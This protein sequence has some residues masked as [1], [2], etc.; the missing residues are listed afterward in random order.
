MVCSVCPRV[1]FPCVYLCVCARFVLCVCVRV[2]DCVCVCPPPHQRSNN[3]VY[4]VESGYTGPLVVQQFSAGLVYFTIDETTPTTTPGS[5]V[6]GYYLR[7]RTC[8]CVCGCVWE[9]VCG[10]VWEVVRVRV[11][12]CVRMCVR[13][14]VCVRV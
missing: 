10:C 8:G 1:S 4:A 14:R 7:V 11:R 2:C 13:E 5:L 6:H 12:L 9:V 3:D